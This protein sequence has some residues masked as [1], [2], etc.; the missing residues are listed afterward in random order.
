MIKANELRIGNYILING[1]RQQVNSINARNNG[2]QVGYLVAGVEKVE[3]CTS[4]AV[5]PLLLNNEVLADCGFE[6]DDYYKLWQKKI[7]GK[8]ADMQ[9]NLDYDITDFMRRPLIKAI[10][11]LHQLQNIYFALKGNELEFSKQKD[12][13]H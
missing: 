13:V 10:S 7:D 1:A 2:I 12:L 3:N 11:S 6:F 5:Q 8:K 9:I 4:A